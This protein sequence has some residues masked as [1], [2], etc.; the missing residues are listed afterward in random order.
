MKLTQLELWDWKNGY[1]LLNTEVDDVEIEGI[2]KAWRCRP[3][4]D[5]VVPMGYRCKIEVGLYGAHRDP[6]VPIGSRCNMLPGLCIAVRG[7]SRG[8]R[9]R[10][11]NQGSRWGLD[12]RRFNSINGD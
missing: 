7:P 10:H 4:R 1:M 11:R 12:E 2:F 5:L 9:D 6:E 3:H 8:H